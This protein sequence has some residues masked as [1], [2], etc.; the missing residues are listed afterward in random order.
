MVWDRFLRLIG[1]RASFIPLFPFVGEMRAKD[2][3]LF[4][5]VGPM[6]P[7]KAITRWREVYP[8]DFA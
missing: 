7:S 3:A 4:A 8:E 6:I 5:E 1:V 2:P